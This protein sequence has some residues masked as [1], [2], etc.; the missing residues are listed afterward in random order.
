MSTT[1]EGYNESTPNVGYIYSISPSASELLFLRLLLHHVRGATS[2]AKVCKV[3][4]H[5][6][7]TFREVADKMGLLPDNKEWDK[8]MD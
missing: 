5:Q 1:E 2:F 3:D 8:C 7:H 4:G 6:D